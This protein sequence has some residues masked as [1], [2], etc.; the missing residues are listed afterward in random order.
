MHEHRT[1]AL[2]LRERTLLAALVLVIG[3]LQHS[4]AWCGTTG[5]ESKSFAVNIEIKTP[6]GNSSQTYTTKCHDCGPEPWHP[7][8]PGDCYSCHQSGGEFP[9]YPYRCTDEQGNFTHCSDTPCDGKV[10]DKE[11]DAPATPA[12]TVACMCC[13]GSRTKTCIPHYIGWATSKEDCASR[14]P[15]Q[16][17]RCDEQAPRVVGPEDGKAVCDIKEKG[18][19]FPFFGSCQCTCCTGPNC[20]PAY[21]GDASSPEDCAKKYPECASCTCDPRYRADCPKDEDGND[22]ILKCDFTCGESPYRGVA[23]F[24]IVLLGCFVC[25][26]CVGGFVYMNGGGDELQRRIMKYVD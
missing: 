9:G 2:L 11:R 21:Q 6:V 16:C 10:D 25:C 20:D 17:N 4:E 24:F 1:M 3:T 7:P 19:P 8:T 15:S 12:G 18:V 13:S 14:F 5:G 26:V 23:V 22:A